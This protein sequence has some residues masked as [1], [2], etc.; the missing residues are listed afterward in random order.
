MSKQ[1]AK[2][3]FFLQYTQPTICRN[4]V[5]SNRARFL[6]DT[7]KSRFVDFQKVRIQEVQGEL[8]R[9]CIPRR[10]VKLSKHFLTSNTYSLLI[11]LI[12]IYL[13]RI[14]MKK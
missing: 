8:P 9:G 13:K 14:Q 2:F 1:L 7:N 12:K 11:F 6:L 5:C 4:P 10:L 3:F